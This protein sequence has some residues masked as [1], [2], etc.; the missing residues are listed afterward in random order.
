MDLRGKNIAVIGMAKTGLAT[1]EF[2]LN[3]GAL[4]IATD[5]R[6]VSPLGAN[7]RA[8]RIVPH[9]P[10]IL[11]GVELVIPSPGVPP[12]NPI[13]ME[14]VRQGIPVLSEIELASRF[15]KPPMI[16]ITGTNGKT[17]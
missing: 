16:A 17:T 4:V 12:A 1:T 11:K 9:D 13:L 10:G 3:R 8:A 6:P 7:L 2:L 15:L 14:A 5:E